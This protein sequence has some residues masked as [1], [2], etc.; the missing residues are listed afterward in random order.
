MLTFQRA[1]LMTPTVRLHVSGDFACFTSPVSKVERLSYP[2]PTPSA[3]RNILDAILWKPEFRWIVTRILLVRHPRTPI[4]VDALPST[5]ALK[6]NE[7]QST[8]APRTVGEWMRDP[9]SYQPLSAGAGQGTDST[10]RMTT[11]L[12]DVAYV[13]EAYPHIFNSNGGDNTPQKYAA[14]LERRAAKGQCFTR[15]YL[16]CREFAADFRLAKEQDTPMK[17]NEKLGRMLY[18]IAH[19]SAGRRPYFFEAELVDGVMLT[20]PF[21]VLKQEDTRGEVLACSYKR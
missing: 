14:M 13:I 12:K 11:A 20:D 18:D 4:G 2:V 15:P 10:P 7:V 9:S 21:E 6:R 3:A 1:I 16:G 5:I 8:I 17:V 19:A